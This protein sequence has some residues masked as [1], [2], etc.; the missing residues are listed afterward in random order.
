M[1]TSYKIKDVADRSGFTAAT[2]R[3]YEEI[4]LLP[5]AS[6]TPAG[7]RLYDDRT[8]DRLAFISRAKQLG[9]SLD[10]I[11]ELTVAWDGGHCGPVQDRLRTLVADKLA[12]ARQQIVGLTALTTDLQRA[13]AML[14]THRPDGPCD[15]NCGCVTDASDAAVPQPVSLGGKPDQ[16]AAPI[17]CTLRP[18]SIDR[19]LDDWRHLLAHVERREPIDGGLRATLGP[20]T[21]L[22]ELM[23][24]AAAEQD[25]CQFFTFAIT[26][27]SRGTALEVRAPHDALPVLHSLFG[28]PA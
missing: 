12:S 16:A 19:R 18:E 3:Y 27:D 6:R 26:I 15:E 7:Y 11:S 9:C 24:L 14:Q 23:R 22:G 13:A 17:A 21:P 10:E 28:Q 4:G 25:C 1:S 20:A 8:L 2:L 5:E